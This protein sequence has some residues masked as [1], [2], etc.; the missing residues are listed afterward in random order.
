[1]SKSP[2]LVTRDAD[3]EL[4]TVMLIEGLLAVSPTESVAMLWRVY[5]PLGTVVLLKDASQPNRVGVAVTITALLGPFRVSSN[6]TSVTPEEAVASSSTWGPETLT[7]PE[8][9]ITLVLGTAAL[10]TSAGAAL[11]AAANARAPVM[12]N[13]HHH[14]HRMV[15]SIRLRTHAVKSNGCEATVYLSRV[16]MQSPFPQASGKSGGWPVRHLA[17]LEV[18]VLA[19]LWPER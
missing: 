15:P 1:M 9:I 6:W 10:A 12:T 16:K 19:D 14:R 7:P 18:H 2:N 11:M 3:G 13:T 17:S 5:V 4:L 8:G